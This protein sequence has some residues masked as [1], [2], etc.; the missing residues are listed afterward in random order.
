MEFETAEVIQVDNVT[1]TE[2]AE[3]RLLQLAENAEDIAAFERG[4]VLDLTGDII[5]IERGAID[6]ARAVK[7]ALGVGG[8]D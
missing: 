6:G 3:E 7:R 1:V 2:M 5:H 4:V 8:I